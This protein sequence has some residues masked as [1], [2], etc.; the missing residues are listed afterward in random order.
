MNRRSLAA[1]IIQDW[2]DVDHRRAVDGFQVVY[3]HP[4]PL[5]D[6]KHLHSMEPD[7]IR[8]V[9]RARVENSSDGILRVVPRT[10]F[11]NVA[12]GPMQ[13]CQH[14]NFRSRS[15]SLESVNELRID[16]QPGLRSA[17]KRL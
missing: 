17:L 3:L 13:P 12:F 2:L 11:H 5:L 8:S 7:R 9:R 15:D 14:D 16:R 4:A 6:F 10:H 1:L